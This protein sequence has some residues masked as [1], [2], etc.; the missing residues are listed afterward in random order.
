MFVGKNH[1]S[2]SL[3]YT[4]HVIKVASGRQ[5]FCAHNGVMCILN[6]ILIIDRP[7]RRIGYIAAILVEISSSQYTSIGRNQLLYNPNIKKYRSGGIRSVD[8][9]IVQQKRRIKRSRIYL[10]YIE[11]LQTF[12]TRNSH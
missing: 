4:R 10:V 6:D 12:G 3:P 1:K 7:D 11:F 9:G 2:V 5:I 8:D